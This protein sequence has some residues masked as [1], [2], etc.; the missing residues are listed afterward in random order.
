MYEIK[1]RN[2]RVGKGGVPRALISA[3]LPHQ[4][5]L[6]LDSVKIRIETALGYSISRA[7]MLRVAITGLIQ[8]VGDKPI[9]EL[10]R[11]YDAAVSTPA[12]VATGTEG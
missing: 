7:T 6:D 3:S 5:L 10:L 4:C 1:R 8:N 12:P 11:V 2:G 9:E